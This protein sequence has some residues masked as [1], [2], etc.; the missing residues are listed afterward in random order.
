M[1]MFPYVAMEKKT[2]QN[3]TQSFFIDDDRPY[4]ELSDDRPSNRKRYHVDDIVYVDDDDD[5][6]DDDDI[7]YVLS[8]IHI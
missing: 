8:L 3:L 5:D 6:A 4:V 7:V 2:H 1:T